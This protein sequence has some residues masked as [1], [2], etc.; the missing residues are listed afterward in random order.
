MKDRFYKP[1][2]IH[3]MWKLAKKLTPGITPIECYER[4]DV[5]KQE[6]FSGVRIEREVK[7]ANW[8]KWR[9]GL[10]IKAERFW[11]EARKFH[12]IA[13]EEKLP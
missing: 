6:F 12:E 4:M 5:S 9:K 7:A 11:A 8:P 1:G 13:D 2:F 3:H 10:N